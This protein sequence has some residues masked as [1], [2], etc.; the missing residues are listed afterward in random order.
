MLHWLLYFTI[1]W[2]CWFYSHW[3][4]ILRLHHRCINWS[5]RAPSFRFRKMHQFLL[6][7]FVHCGIPYP[8]LHCHVK[9][10]FE[11]LINSRLL[12]F[13]PSLKNISIQMILIHCID[14]VVQKR[15]KLTRLVL[16]FSM[17]LLSHGQRILSI[18]V[19]I[20]ISCNGIKK[21]PNPPSESTS[22]L[23]WYVA[24]F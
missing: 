13:Y 24:S 16:N 17:S 7:G 21:V 6:V 20:L 12:L 11:R 1:I 8:A 22:H 4:L 18:I 5:E 3:K 19:N 9:P 23:S 15:N 2:E 10:I 14:I